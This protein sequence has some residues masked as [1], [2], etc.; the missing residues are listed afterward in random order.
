MQ[1]YEALT[2]SLEDLSQYLI[3]PSQRI[4]GLYLLGAFLLSIPVF[5]FVNNGRGINAFFKFLFPKKIWFAQSAKHDYVLLV[6]N[7]IIRGVLLAPVIIAMVPIALY[8]TE[9][10]ESVFGTLTPISNT[11]WLIMLSFTTL[12]FVLDDLSRFVLHWLLHHVPFLW[13]FHKVH[14]SAKV[15]T[16]ITIYRS[17]PIENYLFASRLAVSQGLAIGISYYLFGPTLSVVEI[18]GA[19]VFVF[20]FNFLGSNLRHSHIWLSW[21]PKVEKWFIS[22][23]QHQIHHSDN[24]EHFDQNLGSAFAIWD[25]MA[26][27]LITANAVKRVNFGVGRDFKEHDTLLGIYFLPIKHSARKFIGMFKPSR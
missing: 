27:S 24:P 12:L 19:N 23:A 20:A 3:D 11:R 6:V 21:G 9:V 13:E 17:H 15:L 16:P 25:R 8:V 7:K 1:W 2:A 26:G 14:H 5:Y 10:L 22:P 18:A 4:F